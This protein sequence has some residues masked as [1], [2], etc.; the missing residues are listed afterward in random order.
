MFSS[1][2]TEESK[3]TKMFHL[4]VSCNTAM[5]TLYFSVK[6]IYIIKPIP[7]IVL[8]FTLIPFSQDRENIS[9]WSKFRNLDFDGFTPFKV[10][11]IRKSH[12]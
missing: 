12:F 9:F 4:R 3:K 1:I 2:C 7:N 10:P 5:K 8:S 11:W 6:S